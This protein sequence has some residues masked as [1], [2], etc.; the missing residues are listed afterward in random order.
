MYRHATPLYSLIYRIILAH[1]YGYGCQIDTLHLDWLIY[2][3]WV[4]E[5]FLIV[6]SLLLNTLH[7]S[8][9]H[10]IRFT[11]E[12]SI[13]KISHLATSSVLKILLNQKYLYIFFKLYVSIFYRD[14]TYVDKSKRFLFEIKK[15]NIFFFQLQAI[16]VF[17]VS[18]PVIIINSPRH[19]QPKAPR[20]MTTLDSVGTGMFI[21]GLLAETYADLQKFSFRQDPVNQGKFCNDGN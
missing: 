17:I 12:T 3:Q 11:V 9:S 15:E 21:T 20:T 14:I 1:F 18:L 6:F 16:W 4:C 19:S 8:I 10:S 2:G 13:Y 5:F 7:I